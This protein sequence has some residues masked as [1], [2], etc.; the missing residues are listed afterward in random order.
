MYVCSHL[1]EG[2]YDW[3]IRSRT[4]YALNTVIPFAELDNTKL[5]IPNC[6]MVPE[7]DFG[8][9]QFAFGS[10]ETMMNYM[11]TYINI[12]QFLSNQ[13]MFM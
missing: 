13:T 9:D 8:N 4:D 10:K 3:V 1:I 5:Y 2:E 11:S 6:R 7:R 12:N